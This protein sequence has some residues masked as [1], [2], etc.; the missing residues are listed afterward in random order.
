MGGRGSGAY[1]RISTKRT[2]DDCLSLDIRWLKRNHFLTPGQKYPLQWSV[3]GRQI[4]GVTLQA[5]ENHAVLLY[6]YRRNGI[7]DWEDVQQQINI[8][9]TDCNYG[10][11]RRWFICPV[12]SRRV[13]VVYG[14]GKYFACRQC[15]NL[16]YESQRE[17]KVSRMYRKASNIRERLGASPSHIEPIFSRPKW[18][19]YKTFR[20]LKLHAELLEERALMDGYRMLKLR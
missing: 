4:G 5:H 18:M 20:W 7:G 14:P 15:Y 12:C 11:Q 16:S 8:T 6:R 10:G 19:H 17:N 3:R 1:I 9:W 2:T 13:A